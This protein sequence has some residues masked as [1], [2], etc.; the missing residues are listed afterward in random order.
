[1]IKMP[2]RSENNV[3]SGSDTLS[4]KND[5]SNSSN[6]FRTAQSASGRISP[7]PFPTVK[8]SVHENVIKS[9]SQ[10]RKLI[11]YRRGEQPGKYSTNLLNKRNY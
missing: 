9:I 7:L 3:E 6:S 1:M 2:K 8:Y 11:Q 4:D 5:N 10:H